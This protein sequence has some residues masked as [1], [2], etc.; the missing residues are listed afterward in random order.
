MKRF[1]VIALTIVF[2][3]AFFTL[4]AL[5]AARQVRVT[6]Y[7]NGR[8]ASGV[9]VE[10]RMHVGYVSTGAGLTDRNG[11]VSLLILENSTRNCWSA[12]VPS[13]RKIHSST[14]CFDGADQPSHLVLQIP[15]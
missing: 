11:S 1:T 6:V 3:G 10:V 4:N 13:N 14:E 2:L 9:Q 12:Y 7:Q 15:S 8:P 5:A